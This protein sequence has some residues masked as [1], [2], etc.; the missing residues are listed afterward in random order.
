VLRELGLNPADALVSSNGTVVRT[1]GSELLHRTFLPLSTAR[2]LCAHLEDFRSTLVLTFDNVGP[3]GEDGRGSLVVEHLDDL[4]ASI[5]GWMRANESYISEVE[6]LETALEGDP[7]I[8]MMLCGPLDR[9]RLAEMRLL[10]HESVF[11]E[12]VTPHERVHGAEVAMHRTEYAERDLCI[13]DLLPA[14]CSKGS[15]VLRHAKEQGLTAADILAIGDNWND[16]SML[17][18]AGQAVVMANAPEDLKLLAI[19]RG[20]RVGLSNVEDGVAAAIEAAMAAS[21]EATMVVS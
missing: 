20:W 3:D 4:H 7:P 12:G 19:E 18:V 1:I 17:E 8:Q 16:V 14:G 9:M 5:G 2:W 13:V 11:A 6:R 21:H 15:A 10:E